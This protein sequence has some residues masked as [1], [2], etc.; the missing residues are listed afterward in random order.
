M[1]E[2]NALADQNPLS[3]LAT[4]LRPDSSFGAIFRLEGTLVEMAEA[5]LRAWT[6]VS[7][8]MGLTPLSRNEVR[9]A[10]TRCAGDA[11]GD[12]FYWTTDPGDGAGALA[13]GD[14]RSGARPWRGTANSACWSAPAPGKA[15]GP[16]AQPPRRCRARRNPDP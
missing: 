10:H 3:Q 2:V 9:R 7:S 13:P 11:V 6:K 14:A 8:E 4:R 15:P 5:Q 16:S 1:E 12:V